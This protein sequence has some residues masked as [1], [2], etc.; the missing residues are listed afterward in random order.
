MADARTLQVVWAAG[1]LDGEGCFSL[2]KR[3]S[4]RGVKPSSRC[5]YLT[6]AQ[7]DLRPLLELQKIF[8]GKIRKL[9]VTTAGNQAYIWEVFGSENLKRVVGEL[10]PYLV[11]KTEQAQA[12]YDFAVTMRR[13]QEITPEMVAQREAIIARHEMARAV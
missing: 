7:I 13:G 9:R 2:N 12:V 10:L 3:T 5:P 4:N 11:L 6:A 1:F 8:G